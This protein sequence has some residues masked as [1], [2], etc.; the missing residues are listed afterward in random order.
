MYIESD[1]VELKREL[2]KDIKKEVVAF[3]NTNGGKIYVGIDDD[4]KVVGIESP[5]SVM[6]SI[7]SMIIRGIKENLLFYTDIHLEVI[8]NKNVI[9]VTVK[10]GS[11]KPYYLSDK[12]IKPSGV[13]VRY[14][15]TSVPASEEAIKQMLL[16]NSK[17]TFEEETSPI[18][19]LHF[20]YLTE[21]FKKI[22][23]TLNDAKLKTLHIKNT[24]G[25]F[26][27]L[28]LLFSDECPFVI[29]CGV[30]E[31]LDKMQ[32][33]D[34]KEFSGSILKQI[35][36]C[37]AY[38]DLFNRIKGEIVRLV[39]IDTKDYPDFALREALL[40]AVIHCNYEFNASILVSVFDDR[41]EVVS[42]GSLVKGMTLDDL[43]K[44]ISA[45]RNP[46]I[47][48][49]F[50]RLDYV[51]SFGTG[52]GRMIKCY[53]GFPC[54]PNFDES[55]NAFVTTLPNRNYIPEIKEEVIEDLPLNLTQEEQIL[56]YLRKYKKIT[57]AEVENMLRINQSRASKILNTMS[58]NGKI[59]KHGKTKNVFYTLKG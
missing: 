37:F 27:N 47:A 45:T 15:S 51:E 17:S 28:G 42:L 34:R 12:G 29:K 9:V 56:I 4:G 10:P 20:T 33:R 14:G 5:V 40:N 52:I 49:I 19:N 26:T 22:D 25:D 35:D 21:A 13:Y 31:G 7:S 24:Y 41:I 18:Q 50:H 36:D 6:D 55:P 46:N 53:D 54:L 32:F 11:H 1:T 57:R 16:K 44:G 48:N 39:R 59:I 58:S 3:A 2:T 43:Y 30:F 38:F 23:I 8:E